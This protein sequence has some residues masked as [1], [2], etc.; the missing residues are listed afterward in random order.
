MIL[1]RERA[2]G[3]LLDALQ[4][5]PRSRA[6]PVVL[7]AATTEALRAWWWPSHRGDP[8]ATLGTFL[9]QLRVDSGLSQRDV[10]SG[11]GGVAQGQL[12]RWETGDGP[13]PGSGEL[14]AWLEA[15]G[16]DEL[17]RVRALRC[18]DADRRTRAGRR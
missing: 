18:A 1:A 9:C 10:A 6:G 3:L 4:A 11:M 13:L 14:G 17:A 16:A 12:S 8:G 5:H 2:L 15:L 7:N